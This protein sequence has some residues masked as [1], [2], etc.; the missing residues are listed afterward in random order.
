MLQLVKSLKILL[1]DSMVLVV[2]SAV[3]AIGQ[4]GAGLRADFN[5]HARSLVS[6]LIDKLKDKNRAVVEATQTT[7]SLFFLV[8][9]FAV[10]AMLWTLA[11]STEALGMWRRADAGVRVSSTSVRRCMK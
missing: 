7:L 3:K 11:C 10:C 9:A 8:I 2:A 4:L 5:V 1:S 6:A